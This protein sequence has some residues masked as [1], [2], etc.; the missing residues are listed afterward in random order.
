ML[1]SSLANLG[2]PL[3][4]LAL[5]Y[6]LLVDHQWRWQVTFDS[7]ENRVALESKSLEKCMLKLDRKYREELQQKYKQ[8]EL[9]IFHKSGAKV[10]RRNVN[11]RKQRLEEIA[12]DLEMKRRLPAFPTP[13]IFF[14]TILPR[15]ADQRRIEAKKEEQRQYKAEERIGNLL[16]QAATLLASTPATILNTARGAV[17]THATVWG[18]I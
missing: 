4:L 5:T 15:K 11:R 3:T 6:I 1:S 12:L 2:E 14:P 7:K 9:M 18:N 13:I 17:T 16:A 8:A 10:W